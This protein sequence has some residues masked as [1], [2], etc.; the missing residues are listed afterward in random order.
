VACLAAEEYALDL[1]TS[2]E[3]LSVE[4]GRYP[5]GIPSPPRLEEARVVDEE[6]GA[7]RG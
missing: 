4:K 7:H 2:I 5:N 3:A 1:S 6:E